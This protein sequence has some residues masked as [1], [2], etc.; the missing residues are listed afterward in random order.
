MLPL[1]SVAQLRYIFG[2]FTNQ[3]LFVLLIFVTLGFLFF[4]L[5]EK[6]E[7]QK[8]EDNL[9]GQKGGKSQAEKEDE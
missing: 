2:N 6:D 4:Y 8:E 1:F 5:N 7:D 3:T 9:V